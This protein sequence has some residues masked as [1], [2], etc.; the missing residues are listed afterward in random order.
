VGLLVNN[1]GFT[2]TGKFLDSDLDP[3]LALLHVNIRAPLILTHHFGRSMR[4]RGR[5]GVIFI[6]STLAFAGVPLMANYAGSKAH[7]LVFA[8][9]LAKELR[10][11]GISVLALC[12]GPTRTEL[13]P[14][15][16]DPG[17]AMQPGAVVDIALKNLGR[18]TTV[19]AGWKNS[20]TTLA[21]RLLPRAGTAAIFGRVVGG[22]LGERQAA[23]AGQARTT[24]R[25][26]L[27]PGPASPGKNRT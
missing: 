3:E 14:S 4:R 19:V 13:W 8:E 25:N 20:L 18:R 1:A 6:A 12:P 27:S 16:A 7:A 9:G 17:R 22:M 26:R 15:G 11:D 5:G 2:T 24:T 23:H 21:T 10:H